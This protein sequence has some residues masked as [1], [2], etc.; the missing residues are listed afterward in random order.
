MQD[1]PN[2]SCKIVNRR[3]TLQLP[4][5]DSEGF[6]RAQTSIGSS[7]ASLF[8]EEGEDEAPSSQPAAVDVAEEDPD[9][10]TVNIVPA[11]AEGSHSKHNPRSYAQ[12]RSPLKFEDAASVKPRP[13]PMLQSLQR[14]EVLFEDA[15]PAFLT[16]KGSNRELFIEGT[17]APTVNLIYEY[18]KKYARKDMQEVN[19]VS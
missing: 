9:W 14:P 3:L 10:D 15:L 11:K 1:G 18:F 4:T 6:R 5:A 7:L 12:H 13:L 16:I 17:H 2:A 8:N 19:H